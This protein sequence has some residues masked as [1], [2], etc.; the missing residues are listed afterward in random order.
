MTGK[1]RDIDNALSELEDRDPMV[2]AS[3]LVEL[4]KQ[5]IRNSETARAYAEKYAARGEA[6]VSERNSGMAF[7]YDIAAQ[8]IAEELDLLGI[9]W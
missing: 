4:R 9:P 8:K 2:P 5:L 3:V 1:K 6:E 7:A